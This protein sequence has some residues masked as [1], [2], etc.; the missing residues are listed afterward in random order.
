[1]E[2]NKEQIDHP[3][4]GTRVLESISCDNREMLAASRD[5]HDG[6][7]DFEKRLKKDGNEEN[8]SEN[9][10]G[11]FGKSLFHE[12]GDVDTDGLEE[13]NYCGDSGDDPQDVINNELKERLNQARKEGMSEEGIIKLTEIMRKHEQIF[14]T[15][16]HSRRPAKITLMKIII[17]PS[18]RAI[19]V[20][21]SRYS[22]EQR[23]LFQ[24]D[25][26]QLA[27]L[28][29]IKHTPKASWRAAPHS[30][31]KALSRSFVRL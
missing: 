18:K 4:I 17:D 12:D 29:F 27:K 15:R 2:S 10:A 25:I 11:L 13:E 1:M 24:S 31:P 26:F 7:I 14:K 28:G 19:N 5:R 3:I 6:D 9:I 30:V 21:V 16:L 8:S 23:A 20:K 22:T